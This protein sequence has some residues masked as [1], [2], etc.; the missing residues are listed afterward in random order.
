MNFPIGQR[1]VCIKDIPRRE[2]HPGLIS[3]DEIFPKVNR[4]YT[5]RDY[6]D[7]Y[8]KE[9][10]FGQF[11][12]FIELRNKPQSYREGVIE[13]GYWYEYFSSLQ[14]TDISIFKKMLKPILKG[15]KEESQIKCL[16]TAYKSPL[17]H[18]ITV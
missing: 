2:Y 13:C 15:V 9:G 7:S 10:K 17:M 6:F 12:R 11:L 3:Y 5:I 16:T 4:I 18:G 14:K 1:V 8:N